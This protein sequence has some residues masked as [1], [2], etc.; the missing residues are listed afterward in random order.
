M[1]RCDDFGLRLDPF[2]VIRRDLESAHKNHQVILAAFF[3]IPTVMST[4]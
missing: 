2:D 4:T 3:G 1:L